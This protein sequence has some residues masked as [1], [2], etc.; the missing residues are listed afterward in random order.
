MENMENSENNVRN[1][2]AVWAENERLKESVSILIKLIEDCG[3]KETYE[4][5]EKD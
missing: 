2:D 1:L 5:T 4:D 3:L